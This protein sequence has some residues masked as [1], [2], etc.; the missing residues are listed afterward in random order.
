MYYVSLLVG[1]DSEDVRLTS[2]HFG[3]VDVFLSGVWVPVANSRGTWRLESSQVVCRELGY[4][5]NGIIHTL[6]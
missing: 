3:R 6:N 1:P 5:T 2:T 4:S